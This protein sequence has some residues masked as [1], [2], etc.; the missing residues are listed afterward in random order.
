MDV[1]AC[2]VIVARGHPVEDPCAAFL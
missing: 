1:A 2:A